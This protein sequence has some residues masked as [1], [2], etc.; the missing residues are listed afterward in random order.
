MRPVYR[1]GFFQQS[2][3]QLFCDRKHLI[4]M[5]SFRF[6]YLGYWLSVNVFPPQKLKQALSYGYQIL[7][8]SGTLIFSV[9]WGKKGRLMKVAELENG[10]V[11][12]VYLSI[13]Q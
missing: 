12:P 13:W 1:L 7:C 11:F 4:G 10:R 5:F 3:K 6:I 2:T 8:S 9:T